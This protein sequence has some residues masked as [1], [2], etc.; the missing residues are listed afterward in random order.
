MSSAANFGDAVA[1]PR[2]TDVLAG[3]RLNIGASNC[4]IGIRAS[5]Y[6]IGTGDWKG[7]IKSARQSKKTGYSSASLLT[8]STVDRRLRGRN[9]A[10]RTKSQM[11]RQRLNFSTITA[12]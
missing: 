1:D 3:G 8:Q 12:E 2:K 9:Q 11:A 6:L 4:N 7:K 5:C 10:N